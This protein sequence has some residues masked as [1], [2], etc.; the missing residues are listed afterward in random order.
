MKPNATTTKKEVV[1]GRVDE[2][3]GIVLG[4]L[5]KKGGHLNLKTGEWKQYN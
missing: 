2:K 5:G 1:L 4:K 3:G